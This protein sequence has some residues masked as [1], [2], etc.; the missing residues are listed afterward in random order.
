M[1]TLRL[2][3]IAIH[4]SYIPLQGDVISHLSLLY[5]PLFDDHSLYSSNEGT[6]VSE[7]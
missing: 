5:E 1:H 2:I 7:E 6:G 3:K 4:F